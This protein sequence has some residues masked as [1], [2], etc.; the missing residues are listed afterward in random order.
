MPSPE[1]PDPM[2]ALPEG[3]R[4]QYAAVLQ[5]AGEV[6]GVSGV[7][8]GNRYDGPTRT[9]DLVVRV[10]YSEPVTQECEQLTGRLASLGFPV[11]ILLATYARD[12][13]LPTE[14]LF[15]FLPFGGPPRLAPALPLRPG[16]SIVGDGLAPGTLGLIVFD[17]AGEPHVLSSAHVLAVGDDGK[18]K[19]RTIF[20]PA[21]PTGFGSSRRVGEAMAT[22]FV[23]DENGD[24]AI[25][26]IDQKVNDAGGKSQTQTVCLAQWPENGKPVVTISRV[27][28]ARIGDAVSKSGV[29][30]DVTHGVVDG[31]GRYRIGSTAATGIQG[32]RVVPDAGGDGKPLSDFGD[33]GAVWYTAD[34]AGVG[35]HVGGPGHTGKANYAIACQLAI[36]LK[37]LQVDVTPVVQLPGRLVDCPSVSNGHLFAELLRPARELMDFVLRPFRR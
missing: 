28:L 18:A 29:K 2:A 9:A 21:P 6:S 15:S 30:T 26:R 32:F 36:V 33:S 4:Q 25:G 12:V 11:Q 7:D 17:T 19:V 22:G 13:G 5:Q 34:G 31:I 8:I 10:H 35:L 14:S 27:L 1:L 37:I 16:V 23:H 3:L 24:A 20:Q